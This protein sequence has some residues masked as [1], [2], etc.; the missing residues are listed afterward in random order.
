[1]LSTF[2]TYRDDVRALGAMTEDRPP[3]W[4]AVVVQGLS[5]L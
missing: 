1:M 4:L 5:L 3:K 2:V